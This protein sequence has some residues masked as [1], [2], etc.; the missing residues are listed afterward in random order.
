[1]GIFIFIVVISAFGGWCIYK[2]AGLGEYRRIYSVV[3]NLPEDQK[4]KALE[5]LRGTNVRG[6]E[7]G[8]LA[9]NWMGSVWVWGNDGLKRYKVDQFSVYTIFDGCRDD[10]RAKLN[11]GERSN[12]MERLVISS[13][14]NWRKKAQ[15]GNM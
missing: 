10:I 4:I 1:M 3:D 15:T 11:K 9:G 2:Y 12:V 8:V 14:E 13:F 6:A 7:S 5:Q